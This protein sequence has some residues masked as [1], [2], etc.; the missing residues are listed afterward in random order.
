[1][2]NQVVQDQNHIEEEEDEEEEEEFVNDGFIEVSSPIVFT[3]Q[4]DK[5]QEMGINAAEVTKLRAAGLTSVKVLVSSF[6]LFIGG[7]HGSF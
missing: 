2:Q 5:L 6:L 4:L 3:F 1:M 7:S